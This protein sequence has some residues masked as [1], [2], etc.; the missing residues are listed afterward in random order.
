MIIIIIKREITYI[1]ESSRVL[2]QLDPL[3]Y[4]I[5]ILLYTP[6]RW[7]KLCDS[8][9]DTSMMKLCSWERFSECIRQL[10]ISENMRNTKNAVLNMIANEVIIKSSMLRT[11]VEDWICAE[12]SGANIVAINNRGS[13]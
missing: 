12:I 6:S 10:I 3:T 1:H 13:W 5:L 4:Y 11:R 2:G 9:L 7:R 8:N